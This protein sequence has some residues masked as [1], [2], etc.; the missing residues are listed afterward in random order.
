[1][2]S[3]P[4]QFSMSIYLL[5]LSINILG[6]LISATCLECPRGR[7]TLCKERKKDVISVISNFS[8]EDRIRFWF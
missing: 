7:M 5:D 6:L 3:V 4:T 8:F 2:F 1:M